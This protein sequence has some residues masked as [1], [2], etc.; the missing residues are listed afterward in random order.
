M[1]SASMALFLVVLFPSTSRSQQRY[2]K[3]S[4]WFLAEQN[5]QHQWMRHLHCCGMRLEVIVDPSRENGRF[6]GHG[7][8]SVF[9]HMSRVNRMAGIEPSA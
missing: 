5:S 4:N 8:G 2:T 3:N 6:H 7:R 1:K 9:I